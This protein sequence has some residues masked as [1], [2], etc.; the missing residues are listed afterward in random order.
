MKLIDQILHQTG[1]LEDLKSILIEGL[2]TSYN[3]EQFSDKKILIPMISFS[4]ILFRDIGPKEV[5]DYGNYGISIN[6]HN[7]IE[8]GLNPVLYIYDNSIIQESIKYNYESAIIP[9]VLDC[10]KEFKMKFPNLDATSYIKIN[11]LSAESKNLLNSIDKNTN[12]SLIKSL[13]N[14]FGRIFENSNNQLLLSKPYKVVRKN[15]DIRIAYNEREWRKIFLDLH[16]ITEFEPNGKIN[17]EFGTWLNKRKPHLNH[18]PH[19]LKIPLE[20]MNFIFVKDQ[21]EVDEIKNFLGN[22]NI[23]IPQNLII[24]TLNN[25]KG[26]ENN[27]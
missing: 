17:G 11:P 21:H 14:I 10:F 12:D 7:A 6:R 27:N 19:V 18:N 13:R 4:N 23:K 25:L 16:F 8:L 5:I 26:I 9:Q 15:G 22:L 3:L 1:N 24:D 20:S 2:F